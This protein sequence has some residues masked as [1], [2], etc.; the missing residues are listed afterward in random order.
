MALS[1]NLA[2]DLAFI[3]LSDKASAYVILCWTINCI[4]N[5][6]LKICDVYGT[7][8]IDRYGLRISLLLVLVGLAGI[9]VE[10]NNA[11]EYVQGAR[12]SSTM[13]TL[14]ETKTENV[15][16]WKI[17]ADRVGSKNFCGTYDFICD[18]N[19]FNLS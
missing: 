15:T 14:E 13:I 18:Q 2:K 4:E 1:Y 12:K 19:D 8:F 10:I 9:F 11:F 17:D 5:P 7:G 6:S 3:L 16:Y